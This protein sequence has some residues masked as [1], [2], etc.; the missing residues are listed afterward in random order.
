MNDTMTMFS[1]MFGFQGNTGARWYPEWL[2]WCRI[3]V[4]IGHLVGSYLQR[5]FAKKSTE[6]VL[7]MPLPFFGATA[8]KHPLCGVYAY[9][10]RV[11][12]SG[13]YLLTCWMALIFLFAPGKVSPFIYFQF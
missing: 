1:A 10:D 11:T 7:T 2:L 6:D 13:A 3:L 9:V 8:E 12:V 5:L 4:L